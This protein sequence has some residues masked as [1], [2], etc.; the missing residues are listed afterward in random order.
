MTDTEVV[1]FTK[2]G[3]RQTAIDESLQPG[4]EGRGKNSKSSLFNIIDSRKSGVFVPSMLVEEDLSVV[5]EEL[6]PS[7]LLFRDPD[8]ESQFIEA[9][10]HSSIKRVRYTGIIGVVALIYFIYAESEI[11][12]GFVIARAAITLVII[13]TSPAL[14]KRFMPSVSKLV[15]IADFDVVLIFIILIIGRI[16]Y[17]T[18][19]TT[20]LGILILACIYGCVRLDYRHSALTS[21]LCFIV[22]IAGTASYTSAETGFLLVI[23]MV[24]AIFALNTSGFYLMLY[25]KNSFYKRIRLA[26]EKQNIQQEEE[27]VSRLAKCIV[28]EAIVEDLKLEMGKMQEG[29]TT[30]IVM[31]EKYAEASFMFASISSSAIM[32]KQYTATD[33][34]AAISRFV[35]QVD[36][37]CQECGVDRVKSIGS[38]V[39]IVSGLPIRCQDHTKRLI[40]LGLKLLDKLPEIQKEHPLLCDA[41]IR[42]GINTGPCIGGV[43]GVTRFAYDVWGDSVNVASRME[44]HGENNRVHVNSPVYERCSNDFG[45]ES[46]GKIQ[47]KGKGLMHTYFV[48]NGSSLNPENS[49][50]APS[51]ESQ[52]HGGGVPSGPKS[53]AKGSLSRVEKDVDM[54]KLL[55]KY[56]LEFIDP[57]KEKKFQERYYSA[58]NDLRWPLGVYAIVINLWLIF[59]A[60]KL[61]G[62]LIPFFVGTRIGID[63]VAFLGLIAFSYTPYFHG[64]NARLSICGAFSLSSL[65]IFLRLLQ[66]VD[67]VEY[68][69]E[70]DDYFAADFEWFNSNFYFFTSFMSFFPKMRFIDA[71]AINGVTYILM[72]IIY[73]MAGFGFMISYA[74]FLVVFF[75]LCSFI[76]YNM[77]HFIRQTFALALDIQ[78]ES[79]LLAREQSKT[80]QLLLSI[81]PEHIY[82]QLKEFSSTIAEKHEGA[83]ILYAD[84]V[85]FTVMSGEMDANALLSMLNSIFFYI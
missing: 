85:G 63:F 52:S 62:D 73:A 71:V 47:V 76:S 3:A 58:V 37:L 29:E 14:A 15:A 25:I 83:C 1:S 53:N 26:A 5:S 43:I 33:L 12:A 64:R 69:E 39:M 84:I 8:V 74:S 48:T 46:R 42:V 24:A 11:S 34:V 68:L 2:A 7:S 45:F 77:E 16:A 6:H 78:E 10:V 57:E 13:M 20:H 59:D 40:L 66:V 60:V 65:F 38:Y 55:R 50:N 80:K 32:K 17:K 21:V 81:L 61:D 9:Y 30:G 54:K 67:T 44:L 82:E 41:F 70:D 72:A 19:E 4:A 79:K 22:F 27:K 36:T 31:A 51:K 49:I 35:S 28:P 23:N 75:I 18:Q 56:T